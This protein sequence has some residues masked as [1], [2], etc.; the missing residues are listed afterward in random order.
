MISERVF[1]VDLCFLGL[2]FG[3]VGDWVTTEAQR[4]QRGF[5]CGLVHRRGAEDAEGYWL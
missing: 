3:V 4:A 2:V 1:G 5:C